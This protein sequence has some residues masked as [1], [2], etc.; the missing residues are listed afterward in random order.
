MR[1]V[2]IVCLMVSSIISK[3]RY[4]FPAVTDKIMENRRRDD[5]AA[6]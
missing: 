6:M 5:F 3:S 1:K 2:L 4:D